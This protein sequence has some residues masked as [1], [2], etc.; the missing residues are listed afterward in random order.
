[1]SGTDRDKWLM[2]GEFVTALDGRALAE[3]LRRCAFEAESGGWYVDAVD[4]NGA[5]IAFVRARPQLYRV[6]GTATTVTRMEE[7]AVRLSEALQCAGIGH[8]LEVHATPDEVT[9]YAH[10]EWSDPEE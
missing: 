8:V 7:S 5:R 6:T 10:P 4:E 9:A 3:Y 1:M 2:Y